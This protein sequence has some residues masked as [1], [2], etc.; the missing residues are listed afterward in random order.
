MPTPNAPKR[1]AFE[2]YAISLTDAFAE[3]DSDRTIDAR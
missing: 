2:G 3:K 1:G